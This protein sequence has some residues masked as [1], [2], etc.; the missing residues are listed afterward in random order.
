MVNDIFFI[1]I[2]KYIVNVE[3]RNSNMCPPP[4]KRQQQQEQ[5]NHYRAWNLI[6][7]RSCSPFRQKETVVK[8][9]DMYLK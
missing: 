8:I 5:K 6:S 1:G 9:W 2:P 3:Q 7:F 4:K